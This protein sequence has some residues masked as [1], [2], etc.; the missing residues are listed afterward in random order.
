ML[1]VFE[2]NV[3]ADLNHLKLCNVE[4]PCKQTEVIYTF[5]VCFFVFLR[6]NP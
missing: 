6:M 4:F 2:I 1:G 3:A 5:S